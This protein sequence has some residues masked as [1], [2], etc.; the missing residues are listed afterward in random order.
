MEGNK[1]KYTVNIEETVVQQFT[2]EAGSKEEAL[3]MA[4]KGYKDGKLVLEPGECID[5]QIDVVEKKE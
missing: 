5:V 3:K 1:M 2:I 4:E